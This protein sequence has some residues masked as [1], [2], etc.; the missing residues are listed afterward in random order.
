VL[1]SDKTIKLSDLSAFDSIAEVQDALIEREIESLIRLSHHEQFDWM[2]K[3]FGLKLREGLSAWPQF[4]E[5]CERRNLFTHTGGVVSKQYI[6]TCT[7]HKC[8]ITD[9][10]VGKK[11]SVT[12]QY[13]RLA[14]K[15][16][17]EI[18]AKLNHV[19]WRKF[20]PDDRDDADHRLNQVGYELILARAYDIA[21]PILRFGTE[22]VKTHGSEKSRRMMVV[23]L[24]NALRLQ[25]KKEE[26]NRIL[27]KE[28]WSACDNEFKVCVAGVKDDVE[29][30]VRFM[31]Q[32][33]ADG[34]PDKEAYRTWPVFRGLRTNERFMTTFEE[35]FG[36]SVIIAS[37]EDLDLKDVSPNINE[38]EDDATPPTKH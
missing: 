38:A 35:L 19:L 12:P 32:I 34:R 31:K 7:T 14:V 4:V 5:I 24:A 30:V 8:E 36:E 25:E 33:G 23:N 28:D 10:V 15:V 18:G 22:V 17:Y 16:I 37:R 6:E 27:D 13:F 26:A 3:R 29:A 1:T 20:A 11:L 2:E 21:E 9:I